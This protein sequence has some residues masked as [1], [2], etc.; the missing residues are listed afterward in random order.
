MLIRNIDMNLGYGHDNTKRKIFICLKINH[1][2]KL[3]TGLLL[4]FLFIPAAAFAGTSERILAFHSDIIVHEDASMTVT[5]TIRVK[6]SG[7]QIRH[8]IYRDFPTIYKGRFGGKH[9]AGFTVIAVSR[10]KNSEPYHIKD[11]DNGKR[12]YI[13]S[14]DITL[15]PGEYTY[16]LT[17]KT[18]RQLGFFRDYDELYWNVT[19]NGWVFPIEKAS[20]SIE[21]PVG[22]T[23]RILSSTGYTGVQDSK[24]KAYE[25]FI[26]D[27]G[28]IRFTATRQLNAHEGLTIAVSWPKGFVAEPDAQ[29]RFFYFWA[30]NKG[31]IIGITGLALLLLYYLVVWLRVG[32]DPEEGIIVPLYTPPDGM[33]PAVMRYISRMGYDQK[34]FA[35]A[36]INMAVK[37]FLSIKEDD[38]EYTLYKK[39]GGKSP[40]SPE[41]ESIKTVLLGTKDSLTLKTT[42]HSIIS[43]A[44]DTIKNYLNLKY[45]KIYF[46]TNRGYFVAGL[47]I[48]VLMVILS[49]LGE[50]MDKGS[51]FFISIWLTGWSAGVFFL[52]FMTVTLWKGVIRGGGKMGSA[53]FFTLFSLPFLAGEAGGLFA[54]YKITSLAIVLFVVLA[55]FI[56]YLLYHLL[57]APTLLGRKNL[58]KTEGFKRFLAATEKDRLNMLNPPDKT[59]ELFER[60][61]PY[62]LALDLEQEWA[63]QF[64]DIL[65]DAAAGGTG[66]GYSPAWYSGNAW[67]SLGY[68]GFA[69]SIGNAV[70]GAI[71]SSST[72]PGSSSGSGG[73]GS[74]GGGGGG[75]GGGGW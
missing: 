19:G 64:S 9:V 71:S 60:Y 17:Y 18:D 16:Q 13:G 56:N 46:I 61:L 12:V 28:I 75:G 1:K 73:G 8:G 29:T 34:T 74:S 15:P 24:E 50:A 3:I 53:L 27:S 57:K 70:S 39:I 31:T 44:V 67:R 52:L 49:G 7:E 2:S 37:G 51:F 20:A 45:E 66:K 43:K 59:P 23:K 41:E 55:A 69:S 11:A 21:I 62:A 38:G 33:S 10:D 58:D 25:M 65:A 36:I 5:E 26:D 6:S 22:A 35:T 72:A 63:E 30:D 68:S 48:S 14:E 32:K 54:L 42:N 47:F 4:L 40:L